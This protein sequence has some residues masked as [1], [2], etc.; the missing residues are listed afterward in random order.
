MAQK[1]QAHD[2]RGVRTLEIY[3]AAIDAAVYDH[4]NAWPEKPCPIEMELPEDAPARLAMAMQPLS[5]AIELRRYIDGGFIGA[6]PFAV[7]VR[8]ATRDDEKRLNA[9][10]ILHSLGA[11]L[12]SNS[13]PPIGEGRTPIAYEMT[14][15]PSCAL[16]YEDG[17]ADYQ[18]VFRLVYRQK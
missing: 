16:R 11:W 15:L 2:P 13:M 10:G 4:L 5:G 9:A 18:A 14:A 8:F 17:T 12:R 1:R 3:D 6:W 7:L